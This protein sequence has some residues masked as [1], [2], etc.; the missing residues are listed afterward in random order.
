MFVHSAK[1]IREREYRVVS[2]F[3]INRTGMRS[4]ADNS[5]D[6]VTQIASNTGNGSYAVCRI[7]FQ[8]GALLDM[9]FNKGG[10]VGELFKRFS[11][12][13]GNRIE[14]GVFNR[15]EKRTVA[16]TVSQLHFFRFKVS[17]KR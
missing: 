12:C 17:G 13:H 1:K 4:F 7:V 3:T 15:I 8:S 6:L 16:D 11:A 5:A 10:N 9:K 14:P 2:E